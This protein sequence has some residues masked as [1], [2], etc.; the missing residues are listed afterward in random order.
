M[1][2][3]PPLRHEDGKETCAK[4]QLNVPYQLDEIGD[5]WQYHE[6]LQCLV[7]RPGS[8][9]KEKYNYCLTMSSK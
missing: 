2:L 6:G 7:P 1:L 4:D 9:C 3:H 8:E 5:Q